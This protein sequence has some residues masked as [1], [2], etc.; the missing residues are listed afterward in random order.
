MGSEPD[1]TA[2]EALLPEVQALRRELVALRKR[3]GITQNALAA[4]T[5]A[6]RGDVSHAFKGTRHPDWDKVMQPLI[7]RPGR[8]RKDRFP[9]RKSRG[10]ARCTTRPLRHEMVEIG[11]CKPSSSSSLRH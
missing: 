6:H 1:P 9:I 7:E 3:A 10:C 11:G 4:R 2:V 8:R 5:G